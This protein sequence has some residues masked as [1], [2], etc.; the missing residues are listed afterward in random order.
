MEFTIKLSADSVNV[1]LRQ[2]DTG[3]HNLVRQVIDAILEQIK[4]QQVIQAAQDAKPE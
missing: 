4:Q 3:P 2:L 1:I